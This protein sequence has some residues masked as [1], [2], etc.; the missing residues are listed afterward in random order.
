MIIETFRQAIQNVWSNK[1]RTFLTML[2]IIIGVMAVIV[3]VGLG[4]R[5]WARNEGAV[6]A[7]RREMDRT[8]G[9][10]VTLPVFADE[11][12]VREALNEQGGASDKL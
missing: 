6:E 9:L 11:E 2:G 10:R 3:I 4:N 1:L 8:P 7:I 5:S 12:L